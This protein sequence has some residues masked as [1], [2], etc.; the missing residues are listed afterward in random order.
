MIFFKFFV[1]KHKIGCKNNLNNK[2]L[3]ELLCN[4]SKHLKGTQNFLASHEVYC[5]QDGMDTN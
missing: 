1:K 3:L 4:I 5:I 2:I